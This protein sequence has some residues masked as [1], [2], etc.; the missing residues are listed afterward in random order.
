MTPVKDPN[1]E[2]NQNDQQET[3][4]EVYE[5]AAT[6]MVKQKKSPDEVRRLL[7]EQGL[8]E[9]IADIVVNNLEQQVNDAKRSKANKDM[10]Y[11]AL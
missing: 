4:D 5:Y 7:I 10:L 1:M 11:G 8:E 3:A 6:L 2:E 9:E